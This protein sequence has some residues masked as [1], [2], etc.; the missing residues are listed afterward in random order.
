MLTI[1]CALFVEAQEIIKTFQLK[2]E[3]EKHHFQVFSDVGKG[4]RLVIT[5]VG[6]IAAATAVAEISTCYP[7]GK[8]DLL[9]NFGSSAAV[10]GIPIGTVYFC[11]K[12]TE[13]NTVR[14][15]YP[16]L[17]YRHPFGEAELVS[18]GHVRT[19]EQLAG[20]HVA[21]SVGE[22]VQ[23]IDC[24]E[25]RLY[26][27]EAAAI[28]QAANFY[29]G[30][31]QMIFLK[32]VTDHGCMENSGII[33]NVAK[34]TIVG[35]SAVDEKQNRRSSTHTV[36]LRER[37]EMLMQN[38]AMSVCPYIETLCEISH[39]QEREYQDQALLRRNTEEEAER[40][41]NELHCSAVMGGELRQLLFYWRLTGTDYEIFLEDYRRQGRLPA[42]DKREGKRILDE[43][44]A[45]L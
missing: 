22:C 19:A 1:Y 9:C 28:Y 43:L 21:L 36:N 26:D 16:D 2:K 25:L 18:C 45:R 30:P 11:N 41:G 20:E 14:T 32:V 15:F 7:P 38:V 3:T 31:H 39:A 10:E 13:E 17:C 23:S 8:A 42:K 40:F 35:E 29:Y 4:I 44:K 24:A 6:A 34:D 27:M 12:L 33:E 37:M 5:G